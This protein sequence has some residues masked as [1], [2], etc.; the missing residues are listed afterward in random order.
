[1]DCQQF[2]GSLD[3]I[4]GCNK[5]NKVRNIRTYDFSTLYTSIPH[6]SLKDQMV[7]VI[8]QCFNES[9]RK[10]IRIGKYSACWSKTR[11][12]T[13]SV[14]DKDD[15]INHIKWLITNIYVVCGNSLF[16]QTVGIPMGT[17]CA[18]FL[19]NL[20]LYSYEYQWLLDKYE[21]KEFEVLRK[22]NYCF[23]YIDDLLCINNDQSMD[24]L[25]NEIYQK[26]LLPQVIM[27]CFKHTTWIWI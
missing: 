12:K 17:D 3:K 6:K 25:M 18:P 11:G 8:N 1:V 10:F 23:R 7:W 5:R 27:L 19:A 9:T 15:L 14:W 26:N 16:R 24:S 4:H 22:F 20:Y 21:K 13:K 2:S